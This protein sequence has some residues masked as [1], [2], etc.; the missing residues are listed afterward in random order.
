MTTTTLP[1][2]P[3]HRAIAAAMR[4]LVPVLAWG[5]PGQGKTAVME[6]WARSW[7]YPRVETMVAS[8]REP[9]DFTGLPTEV[10]DA[11]EYLVPGFVKRLNEDGGGILFLDEVNTA[12]GATM[13]ACLRGV[14]ERVFGD[15]PLPEGAPI[16]AAANPIEYTPNGREIAPSMANRF[17]HVEWS[18]DLDTW[19]D[20]ITDGFDHV[21][22]PPLDD[23]A[24]ASP[25]ERVASIRSLVRQFIT[26][27]A[28]LL[29]DPPKD[30]VDQVHGWP[31][32]RSWHNVARV[33]EYVRP[34]DDA[35]AAL[36]VEGL[37]G[38]KAAH[39]FLT[40]MKQLDLIDPR[41]ALADPT[42]IDTSARPDRLFVLAHTVRVMAEKGGDVD[43]YKGALAVL[44]RI[45]T[46]RPD[47]AQAV[48]SGMLETMHVLYPGEDILT[49]SQVELFGSF[50]E[51][52]GVLQAA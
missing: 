47:I 38:V 36:V 28:V 4:A 22:V 50:L 10:D 41:A 7:G 33:L 45:G 37:V 16:I 15:H 51:D 44:E 5:P 20:G 8:L 6:S 14:Q 46:D 49:A 19:L 48:V 3:Q 39:Q 23:M 13:A 29:N 11:T 26:M 18:F 32:N 12:G 31:S 24:P 21:T 30:L 42:R 27:N 17:M 9:T 1:S 34:G 25:P 43:T 35:T 40:F 2:I 52:M